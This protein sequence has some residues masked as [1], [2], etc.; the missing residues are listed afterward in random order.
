MAAVA[1][2]VTRLISR[3]N[4]GVVPSVPLR[5]VDKSDALALRHGQGTH[6]DGIRPPG[7]AGVDGRHPATCSFCST[8]CL[9]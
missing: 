5:Q 8:L 9:A 1:V 2:P 3:N 6:P 4:G 7:R